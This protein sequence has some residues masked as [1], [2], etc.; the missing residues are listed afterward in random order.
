MKKIYVDCNDAEGEFFYLKD[1]YGYY[2]IEDI[3]PETR[4][5]SN[6]QWD[7]YWSQFSKDELLMECF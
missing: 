4:E 5:V 6:A 7:S 2:Y 1:E 3:E